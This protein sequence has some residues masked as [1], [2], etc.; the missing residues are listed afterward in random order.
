MVFLGIICI[1]C[2]RGRNFYSLEKELEFDNMT[3]LNKIAH[4][5]ECKSIGFK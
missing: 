1:F 5:V 2:I 4:K 3:V